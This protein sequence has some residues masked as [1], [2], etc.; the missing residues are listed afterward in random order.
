MIENDKLNFWGNFE[1][2][3]KKRC[4][5]LNIFPVLIEIKNYQISVTLHREKLLGSKNVNCVVKNELRFAY[6]PTSGLDLDCI[7][8]SS[9]EN[10]LDIFFSRLNVCQSHLK[11]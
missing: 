10:L 11:N 2:S 4:S 5:S 7:Y 6:G 1:T 9:K 3:W 8:T